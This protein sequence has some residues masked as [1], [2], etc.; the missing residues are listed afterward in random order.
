M[1]DD[2]HQE[3]G[4]WPGDIYYQVCVEPDCDNDVIGGEPIGDIKPWRCEVCWKL[5]VENYDFREK[6]KKSFLK[7]MGLENWKPLT[8]PNTR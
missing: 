6:E 3:F 8:G 2:P 5:H 1:I 4:W 7:L